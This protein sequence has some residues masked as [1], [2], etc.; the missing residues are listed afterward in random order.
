MTTKR[1][2]LR[3]AA[4]N[5]LQFVDS[6]EGMKRLRHDE[7]CDC[8]SCDLHAALETETEREEAIKGLVAALQCISEQC[9][10]PS[11]A[12]INKTRAMARHASI[13]LD[14]ARKAGLVNE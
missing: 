8:I 1:P 7:G 14:A 9:E 10:I 3:E 13:A 4:R 5:A 12:P 11:A 6:D 2:T